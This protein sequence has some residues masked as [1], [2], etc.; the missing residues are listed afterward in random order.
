MSDDI[1]EHMPSTVAEAFMMS[2]K[3]LAEKDQK[4]L[5]HVT[6]KVKD[7]ML[8]KHERELLNQAMDSAAEVFEEMKGLEEQIENLEE[9]ISDLE[10]DVS[11]LRDPS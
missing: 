11:E 6:R 2:M 8:D 7:W 10:N 9:D 4:L 1:P 3:A 5:D